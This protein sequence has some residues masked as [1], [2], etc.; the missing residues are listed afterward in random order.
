MKYIYIYFPKRFL[1]FLFG[2]IDCNWQDHCTD[3]TNTLGVVSMKT[4]NG[5]QLDQFYT[6]LQKYHDETTKTTRIHS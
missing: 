5:L 2:T 4:P 6:A 3:V 1:I